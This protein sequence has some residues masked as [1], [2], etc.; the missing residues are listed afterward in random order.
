MLSLLL[1]G[2]IET[3]GRSD[4]IVQAL[5]QRNVHHQYR[6]H[7][8]PVYCRR[9]YR[10]DGGSSN[11]GHIRVYRRPGTARRE[12]RY[13]EDAAFLD[14]G[15]VLYASGKADYIIDGSVMSTSSVT[16]GELYKK[17]KMVIG[18]SVHI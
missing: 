8:Y 10:K 5:L 15:T 17:F 18:N 9:V 4:L 12:R 11:V 6:C 16:I 2:F 3:D 7:V 1:V 13:G 14:V